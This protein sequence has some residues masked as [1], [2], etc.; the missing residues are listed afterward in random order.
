MQRL[1]LFLL[2]I[3]PGMALSSDIEVFTVGGW[4]PAYSAKTYDLSR[5]PVLL[6]ELNKRLETEAYLDEKSIEKHLTPLLQQAI[7]SST[8]ATAMAAKYRLRYLP[9]TVI[10]KRYVVYGTP[11]VEQLN[12]VMEGLDETD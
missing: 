11:T 2:A 6:A 7:A 12:H 8:V 4:Q 5:G 10:N 9:A 3:M 1:M